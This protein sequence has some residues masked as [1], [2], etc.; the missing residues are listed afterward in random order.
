MR[1]AKLIEKTTMGGAALIG[2]TLLSQ[3]AQ[4]IQSTFSFTSIGQQDVSSIVQTVNGIQLTV[5]ARSPAGDFRT[6]SS[7]VCVAG[8][9]TFCTN[10]FTL[11]P[12]T[13]LNLTFDAPVQLISYNIGFNISSPDIDLT[14]TQGGNVSAEGTNLGTGDRP[15][16]N[17]FGVTENTPIILTN[18]STSGQTLQISSITVDATPVPLESDAWSVLGA[19]AFLGGGMWYKRR[20]AQAKANLSL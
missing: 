1:L 2:L 11:G 12:I 9:S 8:D 3:P 14:F 4:A 7:G 20:R 6:D 10:N 16:A 19:T 15:F 18:Q 5:D 13:S 17:Q